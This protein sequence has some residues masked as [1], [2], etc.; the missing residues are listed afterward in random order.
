MLEFMRVSCERRFPLRRTI[1]CFVLLFTIALTSGMGGTP[2]TERPKERTEQLYFLLIDDFED[3]NYSKDPSW[4]KFDSLNLVVEKN[5]G[6]T[7][8]DP[9]VAVVVGDYSLSLTGQ[10]TNWYVGGC[11]T[12]L[13]VDASKY[14][15]LSMD[16]Y[17][18]GRSSGKLKIEL[19]DDDNGNRQAEADPAQGYALIYDDKFT[20]E[21]VVSWKGWERI[22]IPLMDFVDNNPGVGDDIWNPDQR[23]GSGG[24]IQMNLIAIGPDERGKVNFNLD[25]IKLV[26]A[27]AK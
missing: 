8:G 27:G 7:S 15:Y 2:Q 24:L 13:A 16:V 3:G 6:L 23:N 10:A 5:T 9:N 19:F 20:Y 25:N 14:S 17:G 12:Y 21:L 18:T 11:G 4:W 26:R 22:S 1:I